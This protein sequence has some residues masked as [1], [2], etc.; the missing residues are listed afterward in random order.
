MSPRPAPT[1][2]ESLAAAQAWWREAGV[3]YAFSD[4][5]ARWLADEAP[6]PG[7]ARPEPDAAIPPRQEPAHAPV[8][9]EREGWPGDFA[10][11]RGWW[12]GE[13]SLDEGGLHPRV[14]PRGNPDAA[15]MMMVTMPE[16]E[17]RDTLL[18]GAQGRMLGSFAQAA[19]LAS[20]AVAFGSALPRHTPLPDWD[21]LAAR[22]YGEVLLHLLSLARPQRLI[23]F[24][25]G[26]LPLLGHSPA[27]GAPGVS[28]L[29]IQGRRLPLLWTYAPD[30]L[31]R[32]ARERATLW[33]RW[34]EWTN[35]GNA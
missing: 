23:V 24:G 4:R 10:A 17:D 26:I 2:A 9:G 1:L 28:E 32:S 14:P 11:F 8:G 16:A 7:P 3:D 35:D 31:L 6:S 34:L 20:D 25:R 18:S 22:G 19:G 21:R 29:S 33:R 13:P 27:Q 5:P 30:T 12:L 15:L